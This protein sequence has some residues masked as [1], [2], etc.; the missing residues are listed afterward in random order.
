M[1]F[2][3]SFN[4][5]RASIAS[6]QISDLLRIQLEK[7][8]VLFCKC[9]SHVVYR[10]LLTW[11]DSQSKCCMVTFSWWCT[12]FGHHVLTIPYS[13]MEIYLTTSNP[14]TVQRL[15]QSASRVRST[16]QP[17][18][19]TIDLLCLYASSISMMRI[20]AM[21][22]DYELRIYFHQL[23]I[24]GIL[25]AV[26]RK[27][28]S[29]QVVLEK[30]LAYTKFYRVWKGFLDIAYSS[31]RMNYAICIYSNSTQRWL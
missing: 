18:S 31:S 3:T 10:S 11:F 27:F 16:D 20:S 23:L 24:N 28:I 13:I 26:R 12:S 8:F 6:R 15:S 9:I 5:L 1:I 22:S 29:I 30:I 4:D 7:C 17:A 25:V 21:F 19:F 14:A 2:N